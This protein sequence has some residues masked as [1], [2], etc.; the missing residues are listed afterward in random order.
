MYIGLG[1]HD[2]VLSRQGGRSVS[3]VAVTVN[4]YKH[5]WRVVN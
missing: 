3:M 4:I 1:R 2:Q 5:S